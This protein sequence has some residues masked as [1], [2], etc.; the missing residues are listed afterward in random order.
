MTAEQGGI[1]M[2]KFLFSAVAVLM[3]LQTQPI[4]MADTKPKIVDIVTNLKDCSI[5]IGYTYVI[6]IK[7]ILEDGSKADITNKETS[8]SLDDPGLGVVVGN[9]NYTPLK[10]G[11]TTVRFK[12]D[13][14]ERF[15]TITSYEL[16]S[17]LINV[18]DKIF[19]GDT[20]EA[21]ATITDTQGNIHEPVSAVWSSDSSGN[22]TNNGNNGT[23]SVWAVAGK[24]KV[25]CLVNS[26]WKAE[27][28]IDIKRKPGEN[29]LIEFDDLNFYVNVFQYRFIY[30]RNIG[31]K[32]IP[33]TCNFKGNW[34]EMRQVPTLIEAG[35]TKTIALVPNYCFSTDFVI[36]EANLSIK[37]SAQEQTFK[38]HL[39]NNFYYRETGSCADTTF[40]MIEANKTVELGVSVLGK[41]GSKFKLESDNP[42][43]T[44]EEKGYE[45]PVKID[46]L[47]KFTVDTKNPP[48][49]GVIAGNITITPQ[50]DPE[51]KSDFTIKCK[52]VNSKSIM[53]LE[54]DSD[55]AIIDG[56][57]VKMPLKTKFTSAR[58]RYTQLPFYFL[59]E[60]TG[61]DI[62]KLNSQKSIIASN[63]GKY[64]FFFDKDTYLPYVNYY[65]KEL[66]NYD[67]KEFYIYDT[68]IDYFFTN[69]TTSQGDKSI[70]EWV[71]EPFKHEE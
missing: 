30:L 19:T 14:I 32:D 41:P 42:R 65:N 71:T 33:V 64:A 48:K 11:S 36:L 51:K 31:S 7:A 5:P 1:R 56:N 46:G 70:I 43:F 44:F 50:D 13:R 27:K 62:Q 9:F 68:F 22:F 52:L 67:A 24:M 60:K 45:F 21:S 17:I 29:L 66:F 10:A 2:K 69:Q 59:C 55:I 12:V 3:M 20:F 34:L 35:Q 39:I 15:A 25:F 6:S 63:N 8:L 26:H 54:K 28:V 23:L 40:D 18:P 53:I 49:E 58:Y 57:P 47:A 61:I 4:M 16:K 38:L 37:T